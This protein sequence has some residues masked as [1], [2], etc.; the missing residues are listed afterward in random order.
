MKKN[1]F[2]KKFFDKEEYIKQKKKLAD[3]NPKKFLIVPV[4]LIVIAIITSIIGFQYSKLIEEGY[5]RLSNDES[6]VVERAGDYDLLLGGI[7]YDIVYLSTSLDDT[8]VMI[9]YYD[10]AQTE[11]LTVLVV[12]EDEL[13]DFDSTIVTRHIGSRIQEFDTLDDYAFTL[14]LESATY[15]IKIINDP[16]DSSLIDY[17]MIIFNIPEQYFNM[18]SLM[19]VVSFSSLAFA[20]MSFITIGIIIYLKRN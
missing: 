3:I 15:N 7:D 5:I 4:I 12:I 18:N 10:S 16:S 9:H 11:V 8:G 14:K 6:I 2:F 13:G 20:V 1:N 17:D 19:N